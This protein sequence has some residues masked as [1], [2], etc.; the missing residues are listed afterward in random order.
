MRKIIFLT[1]LT[2]VA[3]TSGGC[4]VFAWLA[5]LTP[6]D[7]IPAV[8]ELPKNQVILVLVDD[9]TNC[10][11]YPP[12]KF[13]LAKRLNRELKNLNLTRETISYKKVMGLA[14]ST[15]NFNRIQASKIGEKLGADLV[16]CVDITEFSM[17]DD[18]SSPVWT[19]R[20]KTSVRVI[21]VKD[22]QRLWPKD[23]VGGYPVK[24]VET[25]IEVRDRSMQFGP[26]L[27]REMADL[28]TTNITHLFYTHT[29]KPHIDLPDK[30]PVLSP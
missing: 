25:P 29:G 24:A 26:K 2:A 30:D 27:A 14:A 19:G 13:E 6:P 17:K 1:L 21:R 10:V 12:V 8:Y 23:R 15:P 7:P 20:L 22:S 28:M 4:G 3:M 9:P 11:N 16:L 18:P 5:S